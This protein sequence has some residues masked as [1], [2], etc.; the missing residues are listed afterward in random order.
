MHEIPPSEA[1]PSGN[2]VYV[3]KAGDEFLVDG[4]TEYAVSDY[5]KREVTFDDRSVWMKWSWNRKELI[6]ENCLLGMVPTFY[7]HGIDEI[8]VATTIQAILDRG[9]QVSLDDKA[10]SLLLYC[11]TCLGEQTPFCEIKFMLPGT[12]LRWDG[13][14]ISVRSSR[15]HYPR[16]VSL[17]PLAA[18]HQYNEIF[19]EAVKRRLPDEPFVMPLTGGRDSRHILLELLR[20]DVRPS[21]CLTSAAPR[22]EPDNDLSIARAI[23]KELDLPHEMLS[24][25]WPALQNQTQKNIAT[26][27]LAPKQHNIAYPLAIHLRRIGM[28]IFDGIGCIHVHYM[29]PKSVSLYQN[30]RYEELA[31]LVLNPGDEPAV[32]L[33][34]SHRKRWNR[35]LA[36]ELLAAELPRYRNFANPLC[37]FRFENYARR[38]PAN[39]TFGLLAGDIPVACPYLDGDLVDFVSAL[40]PEHFLDGDFRSKAIALA[41]PKM[42][43]FPY[44]SQISSSTSM[45]N[46]VYSLLLL[47]RGIESGTGLFQKPGLF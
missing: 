17:G 16:P 43:D 7:Y 9:I 45:A 1:I 41:H 21:R 14:G 44:A 27:Y 37:L 46:R 26:S 24:V 31:D 30:G 20:H 42:A 33:N 22:E 8:I 38:T 25:I 13:S 6:V 2:Y 12:R 15:R 47:K 29:N 11:D 28:P 34:E 40:P 32:Y 23:C 36:V 5:Q 10:V 18:L 35:N 4:D 3:R 19:S 39:Y